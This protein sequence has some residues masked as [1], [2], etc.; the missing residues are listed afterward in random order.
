VEIHEVSTLCGAENAKATRASHI[1]V[2]GKPTDAKNLRKQ[3]K[4]EGAIF[5][6]CASLSPRAARPFIIYVRMF[7]AAAAG[8]WEEK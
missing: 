6:L 5:I 2:N 1:F 8:L 3:A 4:F 7:R